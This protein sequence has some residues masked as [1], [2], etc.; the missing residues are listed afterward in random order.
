[1]I[2]AEKVQHYIDA[3]AKEAY[4]LLLELAQIPSPSNHE[5]KRLEFCKAWLE[6]HGAKDVYTDDALNVVYP[7]H[8]EGEK[9]LV[10]FMAHTDVV[11]PDTTPL[12]LKEE[13]GRICCPGVGDDTANLVALMMAARYVTEEALEPCEGIG[14]VFVCNAGEEGMGNLKGSRKICET[15]GSRI[16]A[17]YSL[18]GTMGGVVN[19]AVGS[20]RFR[21]TVKTPGGHSYGKFGNPNAIAHLAGIISDIY[22][23]KVPTNGKTT[24]NVGT[25]A[26]GTSVNTIAQE[27]SMLCEFRSDDEGD[28]AFMKE[29][30]DAIFE[31]H[32]KKDVSVT[33]ETVGVRPCEHLNE[34]ERAERDR[35]VEVARAL[36]FEATG[37]EATAGPSSTDCNIPLS[38]GIPS[39]CY[40]TYFGEG[41]HTR[42]EYVEKDSLKTGYAVAFATVLRHTK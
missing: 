15:Y 27:A 6:K 8:A 25:I 37:K 42:E 31:A 34:T 13:N 11:F 23:I 30:Y 22:Q 38:M 35:M 14:L 24:Y 4:E 10:V 16:R 20:M 18:D 17:F 5:K 21:V 3:H 1:M 7:Y 12:P 19:K 41:A 29:T 36:L 26:G 2:V 32:R 33:V 28:L 40:G 9:P 39:V